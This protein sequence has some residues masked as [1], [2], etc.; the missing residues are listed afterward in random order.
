MITELA[1]AEERRW[2]KIYVNQTGSGRSFF[3]L[4]KQNVSK[5]RIMRRFSNRWY[6]RQVWT[7]HVTKMRH[8]DA[9]MS[10][11]TFPWRGEKYTPSL[12]LCQ[13]IIQS[14]AERNDSGI[15]QL[16]RRRTGGKL[17]SARNQRLTNKEKISFLVEWLK[18]CWFFEYISIHRSTAWES[19]M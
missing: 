8:Q 10:Q 1:I 4:N 12:V 2:I 9:R 7:T 6:F 18:L 19:L 11:E 17:D 5:G 13:L 15:I 16:S 3:F 14:L